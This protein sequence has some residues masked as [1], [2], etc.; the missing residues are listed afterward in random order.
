MPSILST[1]ISTLLRHF[2]EGDKLDK[3]MLQ[4]QRTYWQVNE[5]KDR[6]TKVPFLI[7]RERGT[8]SSGFSEEK[9]FVSLLVENIS[10]YTTCEFK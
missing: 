4:A 5:A 1:R 7:T 6:K 2:N 8:M 3:R 9:H 10:D